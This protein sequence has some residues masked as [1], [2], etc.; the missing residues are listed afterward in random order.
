MSKA[1]KKS[2]T[3]SFIWVHHGSSS[4]ELQKRQLGF[5]YG[6]SMILRKI[7]GAMTRI[8]NHFRNYWMLYVFALG[9]FGVF[10]L[11]SQLDV[12]IDFEKWRLPAFPTFP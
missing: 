9:T 1:P 8:V 4:M 7:S 10:I 11:L 3:R 12:D 5:K 2:F 6:G